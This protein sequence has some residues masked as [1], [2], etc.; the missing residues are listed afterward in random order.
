MTSGQAK[1]EHRLPF[2][3]PSTVKARNLLD[4]FV[5]AASLS[6][7]CQQEATIVL[8]E[9]VSNAL[10]HGSPMPG[11]CF[12]VEFSRTPEGL[13]LCVTDGGSHAA[14]RVR[15]V[16]AGPYAARGRGLAMVQALCAEWKVD[17]ETG[18]RVM[19]T[20]SC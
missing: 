4:D 7:R 19:A 17:Q 3:P 15:V 18:T 10:D 12:T 9:L 11:D 14:P 6:H 8:G 20:L 13:T 1:E 16:N 5:R 2:A